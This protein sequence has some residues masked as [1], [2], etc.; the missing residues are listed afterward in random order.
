MRGPTPDAP[1]ELSGQVLDTN[2][3]IGGGGPAVIAVRSLDTRRKLR[4]GDFSTLAQNERPVVHAR[5]RL[6]GTGLE[7]F[8]DAE[9]RF[10]LTGVPGGSQIFDI[11]PSAAEAAP[12]GSG[13]AGFR[14]EIKLIDGVNNVVTV[15]FAALSISLAVSPR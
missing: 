10:R 12:D 3:F 2:S 8:T 9:G 1:T 7:T 15:L 13:Y 14:G 11:D 5:I 4:K 6:M